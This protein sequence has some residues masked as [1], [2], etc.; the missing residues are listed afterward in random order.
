[1]P[2]SKTGAGIEA[3]PRAPTAGTPVSR[4][5][6]E[7]VRRLRLERG[8]SVVDL[9]ARSAIARA[10][11]TQLESGR[12]NP[13]IETIS[14]LAA[15]LGAEADRLLRYDPAPQVLVVRDGEG[16]RTSEIATLIDRHPHDGGRTEVFDFRLRAG[17][18]ERSTSHGPG[19][20]EIV[21]VRSGHLRVGPLEATVELGVGDYAAFSADCL[22]EY[23]AAPDEDARFWLV[24]R[25]GTAR[26]RKRR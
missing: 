9:A 11:L 19:S 6:G 21:L 12:G 14:A 15:V 22:H 7:N 23:V 17:E 4:A 20:A 3:A 16:G 13:T 1:M 8:L 5:L 25:Y 18:R 26:S 10:T 2:R 24:V